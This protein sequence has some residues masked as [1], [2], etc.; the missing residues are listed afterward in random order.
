MMKFP[1]FVRLRHLFIISRWQRWLFPVACCVP[2]LLIVIWLLMRG[3][4]W[5]AQVLLA[6]L[7]MGAV[8]AGLTLWLARQEFR[9]RLSGRKIDQSPD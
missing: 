8:L 4:V 3:L 1:V 5:I 7:V 9:T 6:P 2:Y